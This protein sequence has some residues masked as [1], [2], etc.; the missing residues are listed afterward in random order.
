MVGYGDN[1]LTVRAIKAYIDGALG[2]RG[3]WLLEP[4]SDQPGS[5]GLPDSLDAL[6]EHGAARHRAWLSI[7]H[8]CD[9]RSR[10]SRGLEYL[11]RGVHT[12]RQERRAI[13]A[14]ASSTHSTSRRPTSR[15]SVSLASSPRCRRVHATSDAVFV[16]ARL[17]D[18]ARRRRRLCVAEADEV[19]SDR[20]RRH[21]RAGRGRRSDPRTTTR[22]SPERRRRDA[23]STVLKR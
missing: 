3:A 6:K 11:R 16:P 2:S 17:G 8:A 5:I 18:T 4:Y 14:G 12:V 15:A 7:V 1:R 9:R 21:R 19:G 20:D 10:K 23:C 22:R 13:C